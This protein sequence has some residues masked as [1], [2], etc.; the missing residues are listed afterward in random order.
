MLTP[1]ELEIVEELC[2]SLSDVKRKK[3]LNNLLFEYRQYMRCGSPEECAQRKEWMQMSYEDIRE[4]FNNTVKALQREVSDIRESYADSKPAKKKVGRPKKT[5]NEGGST[6]Y[7]N[8]PRF[9]TLEERD[10]YYK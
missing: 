7:D 4:N 10:L 5:K 6:S 3:A 8:P 1:K 9:N 2:S